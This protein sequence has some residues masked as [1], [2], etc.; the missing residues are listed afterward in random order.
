[1]NGSIRAL[2]GFLMVYGAVGGMEADPDASLALL[3]VFTVC[4]LAIMASGVFAMRKNT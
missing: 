1:M 4:G 3:S 2:V